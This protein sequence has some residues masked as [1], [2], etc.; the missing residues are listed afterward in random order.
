MNSTD[1]LQQLVELITFSHI[2]STDKLTTL[3]DIE[4]LIEFAYEMGL[5]KIKPAAF[6]TL[7]DIWPL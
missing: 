6:L 7:A 1:I 3:A 2:D 4:P 5:T